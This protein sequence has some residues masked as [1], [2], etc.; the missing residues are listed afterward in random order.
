MYENIK[1]CV[2]L[3]FEKIVGTSDNEVLF[4]DY[5][6]KHLKEYMQLNF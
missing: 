2:E 6:D 1:K 4:G 5:A 3:V